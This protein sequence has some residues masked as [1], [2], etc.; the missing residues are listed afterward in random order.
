MPQAV[1]IAGVESVGLTKSY[2]RIYESL[3]R[4][5]AAN[6]HQADSS[7][8]AMASSEATGAGL[9]GGADWSP[10]SWRKLPIKQQAPYKDP[11]AL[12]K[13]YGKRTSLL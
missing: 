4:A 12:E 8:A 10:S 1:V 5:I 9:A 6:D 11:A 7:H 2:D 13:V 3:L